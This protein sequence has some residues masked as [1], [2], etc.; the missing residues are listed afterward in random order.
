M[1]SQAR[2]SLE[3]WLAGL[4]SHH[5]PTW[6]REAVATLCA[7]HRALEDEL[8]TT[9]QKIGVATTELNDQ[10]AGRKRRRLP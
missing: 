2:D 1:A 7:E 6:V 4:S 5:A 3:D 8:V 10:L 9:I